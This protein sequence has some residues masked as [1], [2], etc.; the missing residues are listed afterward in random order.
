[1]FHDRREAGQKLASKLR[2]YLSQPDTIILAIPRGGVIV[3]KEIAAA[4]ALPLYP[5]ITRKIGA[6][7]NPELAI[8]AATSQ[9]EV[10][11]DE[12]TIRSLGI[13]QAYLKVALLSQ[14]REAKRRE[15]I[16]GRFPDL[17]GK[18]VILVDDGIATGLTVMLCLQEVRRFQPKKVVLAVPIASKPAYEALKKQVDE[19]V[20][21]E[22]EKDLRSVGKYYR[23]FQQ[24]SD[25]EVRAVLGRASNQPLDK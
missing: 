23:F 1:M 13:D 8:G 7:L 12:A 22:I 21:L 10:L 18:T 9:G 20:V 15:E 6:P 5:I 3:G 14:I 19:S 25:E 4:L 24:V 11:W 2:K 17:E 16:Y